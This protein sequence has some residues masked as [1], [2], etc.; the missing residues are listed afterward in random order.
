M[1]TREPL[2]AVHYDGVSRGRAWDVKKRGTRL[3]AS[4]GRGARRSAAALVV[5][6]AAVVAFVIAVRFGDSP[7][8]SPDGGGTTS[9]TG[10][11]AAGLVSARNTRVAA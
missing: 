11:T 2:W 7:D 9:A 3:V 1:R 5:C 10:A 4:R 8:R 6:L